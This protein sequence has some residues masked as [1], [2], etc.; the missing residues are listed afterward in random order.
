M[1]YTWLHQ[2]E[3]GKLILFFNGWGCDEYP[4]KHMRGDDYNVLM[5]NNYKELFLS[6]EILAIINAY[7]E[8]RVIAWSFGVWVAQCLL[9]TLKQNICW[10][11]AINGTGKPVSLQYGIPE[12]IAQ[13]TLLGLNKENLVKFQ[14][15][16]LKT[17][18]AWQQFESIKPR[19]K[20]EEIKDELFLL[21]QYFKVQ[22]LEG[23]FYDCAIIGSEDL[24]IPAKKQLA[25]WNKRATIIELDQPHF[26]FLNFSRWT[27][28]IMYQQDNI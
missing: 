3:S 26:C 12:S 16:M 8:I 7:K 25:Y 17:K 22:K 6:K 18:T 20:I 14:R 11:I 4:F 28:I 24:I 27:D 1:N 5:L 23:N 19:R 13:G 21:L 9:G 10:A 15:R 2:S